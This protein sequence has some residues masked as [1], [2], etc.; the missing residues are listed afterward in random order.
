[1]SKRLPAIA[2]EW[3]DR[4]QPL[5]F[6][7]EGQRYSGFAGDTISS[8]LH[9][10][11][12]H[13][14]G[15]SFKYHRLRGIASMAN[16]DVN[17]MMQV[18][19]RL[20]LRADVT[21]LEKAIS[22][23]AINTRGGLRADRMSIMDK[24]APLL[25]VGFYYKAFHTP[26]AF[27]PKWERT[28]RNTSGLGEIKFTAPRVKTPKRYDFCD[29][30]V[31]GAGPSGLSAAVA[32]ADA[33]AQ[34]VVV[35]EN[36]HPGG[37]LTYQRGVEIHVYEALSEL[38]SAVERRRNIKMV[39]ATEAAGYYGD[40]WVPL[41][42]KDKITKMRARAVIAA[43]GAFEQP[44]VFR[45]NDLPGIML[46]SAAQRLIY[47]YGVKPF[48]TV[49]VLAANT[50][51]YR[52]ALDFHNNG[53]TVAALLDL[54]S[55][56]ESSE[57]ATKIQQAGIKLLKGYCIY[58]ALANRPKDNV[59]AVIVCPILA[60]GE[61][62][63]SA[64]QTIP[65]DGVAMSVGFTPALNLLYQAGMKTRYDLAVE[66][67][68]PAQ[69]PPGVF[70]AGRVN[71]IYSTQGKI[72][73]GERAALEAARYL[74]LGEP[75]G[76]VVVPPEISSP[77]HRYPIVDH[78]KGKNFVDFDED[79]Q[80]KDFVNA[81]QEGFDNIEL[82]KRY[83]TVG[84]GPSQGKHSNMNA[85]RILAKITG[86]AIH[87]IGTTTARPFFHPVALS[88]LAGRSFYPERI[89][90]IHGRHAA[91]NAKF[92]QAG[93][94]LRPE[95]YQISGQSKDQAVREEVRAV[96][97][98]L[99][100]IDVGTLGKLEVYGPDAAEFLERIYTGRFAT[101]K[102]GMTRYALM[103]DESGVAIDDGVVARLVEQHFYFTTTTTGS[104]TI[105]RELTRLNSMWRLNVGIVNVT[106]HYAAVN[107]AGPHSRTVLQ[108]LAEFDVTE[109][110]FPYLGAREGKVCGMPARLMRVGF[111][112]ELGY[113]I[114]VP[115][116][117]GAAL[118]D[119]L[120]KAGQPFG[121]RPFG[122]EAQRL[123][124]LEKGHVIIG[125]DTDGLTT[126]FEAASGFAVKMDKPFFI[127][128]R[129]LKIVQ[130]KP[131]R[132]SLVAFVLDKSYTGAAPKE[133]HLVIDR[134]DMAGRVT[135]VAMSE[136]L[137]HVI[138]LAYV[139]PALA[140]IGNTINIRIDAGVMVAATIVKPP[141]YDPE[142]ARQKIE[143]PAP[144]LP[145]A[146]VA[147]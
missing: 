9:A 92:M 5:E 7:F 23:I 97:Q 82:M 6:S 77:N 12:V 24:L 101:M 140:T 35:D 128:Q 125:Q 65:C 57:F 88:H 123:L 138:G 114:H 126:P 19:D 91:L 52:A 33:G 143:P 32:A 127:G 146:S 63:S 34:V 36:P 17:T 130:A 94:W 117:Y 137:G 110:A 72:R 25:P 102:V 131:L 145:L 134:G 89:T 129:S 111:V 96:R 56:G 1:M 83:T 106:G 61:P 58:E 142:S 13:A 50:E 66:Q 46:A 16:H 109:T 121:I 45:N 3:I 64:A 48:D 59:D 53:V 73:D 37:S 76:P 122:V 55:G 51:G 136:T 84:M 26:K 79:I 107:L 68:V 119:I 105:Y 41:V 54:R 86:K 30:L 135:S 69:L 133:C 15:R 132:Q 11:G 28:I 108:S 113:E 67:F 10:A 62:Q 38:I 40:H 81:A 71:G 20:N 115:A 2:G 144:P 4:N 60:S 85:I 80:V 43:T 116:E 75:V 139:S 112:G 18:G 98:G 14:M 95:Y 124:R 31:I 70:A 100:V 22:A 8:A 87:E 118:W 78:P 44:A 39:L 103:C 120:M 27:F 42:D 47:R 99:G 147:S 104:A 21:P 141:F 49:V 90:P 93:V 29:V 74:R